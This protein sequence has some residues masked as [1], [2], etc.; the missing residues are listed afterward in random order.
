MPFYHTYHSDHLAVVAIGTIAYY[1]AA[2][3]NRLLK[4]DRAKRAS[5]KFMRTEGCIYIRV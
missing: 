3:Q 1:S 5:P 4:F 2:M